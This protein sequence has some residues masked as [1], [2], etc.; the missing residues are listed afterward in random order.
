MSAVMLLLRRALVGHLMRPLLE[1]PD[2]HGETAN[3]PAVLGARNAE[4]PPLGVASAQLAADEDRS[5]AEL[6]LRENF[7]YGR[8]ALD[9]LTT[10][11]ATV[12]DARTIGQLRA[13]LGDLPGDPWAVAAPSPAAED[14]ARTALALALISVLVPVPPLALG[15][16]A[17]GLGAR[18][19]RTGVTVRRGKALAAVAIGSTVAFVQALALVLWLA[20][21]I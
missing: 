5:R 16:T 6:V 12:Q 14:Q 19:L 10:R 11:V 1:P 7:A 21:I 17:A 4:A 13:A 9:E 3:H 18:S 8:L 2:G 20:G 15:M